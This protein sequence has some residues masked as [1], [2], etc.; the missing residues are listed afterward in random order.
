MARKL[1]FL[2]GFGVGYVLGARAGRSRYDEIAGMARRV[3]R[4]PRVQEKADQAH[5]LAQEKAG[6]AAQLAQEK[7]GQAAHAV[8]ETAEQAGHA[9]KEKVTSSSEAEDQPRRANH[10]AAT[11]PIANTPE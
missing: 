4:D 3:W 1:T 5:H 7:A 8:K 2:V 9:V 11:T 6:Q 10:A